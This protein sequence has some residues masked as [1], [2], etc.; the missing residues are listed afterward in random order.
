MRL[1]NKTIEKLVAMINE[2]TVYRS[3]PMLVALFNQ[4]GGE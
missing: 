2:E 3:G 4:L 1:G